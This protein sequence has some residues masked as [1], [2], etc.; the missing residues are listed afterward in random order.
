MWTSGPKFVALLF[1]NILVSFAIA[2]AVL[3]LS[4]G[5]FRFWQGWLYLA[6]VF[7]SS[8]SIGAYFYC[9]DRPLFERRLQRREKS[10]QQK[11]LRR[12]FRPVLVIA[13]VLPGLDY[14]FGWSRNYLG[15][16]PLWLI[17]LSQLLV[18]GGYVVAFRAMKANSFA[19]STI[20]VGGR[21]NNHYLRAVRHRAASLL[22]WHDYVCTV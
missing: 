21:T 17:L 19:S 5:S 16:V 1:A 18:L 3:F 10:K 4:A 6:V 15:G 13:M 22:H 9:Y 14:R 11:L 7:I 20:Q 8:L 12:I 2:V